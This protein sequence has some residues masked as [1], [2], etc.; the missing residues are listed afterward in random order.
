MMWGQML[1]R[2][3]KALHTGLVVLKYFREERE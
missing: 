3:Q 1:K 2:T